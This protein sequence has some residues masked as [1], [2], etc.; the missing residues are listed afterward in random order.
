MADDFTGFLLQFFEKILI[1][2][3]IILP[4]THDWKKVDC[5][6]IAISRIDFAVHVDTDIRY[7]KQ[8]LINIQ[9]TGRYPV[10]FLDID[11]ASNTEWFVQP[12]VVDSTT[13]WLHI[14]LNQVIA[15][16]YWIW[17]QLEGRRIVMRCRNL[18]MEVIQFFRNVE[19]DDGSIIPGNEIFLSE[20]QME[21]VLLIQWNKAFIQKPVLDILYDME[22]RMGTRQHLHHFFYGVHRIVSLS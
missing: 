13:I 2:I 3:K 1:E 17:F 7:D 6:I 22:C 4:F 8:I 16:L 5:R 12:G 11:S 21:A 14:K 15:F 10:F 9:Q 18:H 20:F 19:S